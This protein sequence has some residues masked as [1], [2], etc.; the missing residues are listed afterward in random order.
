MPDFDLSQLA[1]YAMMLLVPGLV[2]T[3]KKFGLSGNANLALS[4][5]LGF[6]FVG[7]AQAISQGLLPEA[8]LPWIKVFVG[9]LGGALGVS[10]YYDLAIRFFKVKSDPD[11]ALFSK[12][13]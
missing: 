9:G 1:L 8:S 12:D 11:V 2:E 10:G 6:F 13:Q 3:A 7:L 5:V 4:L